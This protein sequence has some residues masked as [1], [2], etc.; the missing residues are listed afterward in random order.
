MLLLTIV[1]VYFVIKAIKKTIDGFN[2]EPWIKYF[3]DGSENNK[4]AAYRTSHFISIFN[5]L[6]KIARNSG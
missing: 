3:G 2:N 4:E 1:F 6:R 5:R